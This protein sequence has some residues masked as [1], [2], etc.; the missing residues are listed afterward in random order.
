MNMDSHSPRKIAAVI[1]ATALSVGLTTTV[2]VQQ[3][4]DPNRALGSLKGLHPPLPNLDGIVRDRNAAIVLDKALFWDQQAGSDGVACASCHFH[5]GADSRIRNQLSPGLLAGDTRFGA[6]EPPEKVG[7][8]GSGA[9]ADSN[10]TLVALDFPFHQLANP[11]DR[12]SSIVISTNDV[13]SSQGTLAGDFI[14]IGRSSTGQRTPFNNF[15]PVEDCGP[16]DPTIFH[17]GPYAAR[18]VEPR[19]APSVVNA[20]SNFRNFWDGRA[21]NIF[22]GVDPFGRRNLTASI[23]VVQ[24]DGSV[25]PV[26]VRLENARLASQ[27]VGPPLSSF[28]M[29]CAGKTFADLGR[30]L[31]PTRPLALQRVDPNDSVLGADVDRA[32]GTGLKLPYASYVAAAF[33]PKYWASRQTLN[34]YS[35]MESNFSFFWGISVMLYESTL[36]SDDSPFDRFMGCPT[37]QCNP[38]VSPNLTALTDAQKRGFEVFKGK[39]RCI[40]CH[41]GPEFSKAATHLQGE[42]QEMGLVERMRMGDGGVALYDNGFYNIGVRPAGEDLGVG[43]K[44]PFGNPLSFTRQYVARLKGQNVRDPF[45]VDPCTFEVPFNVD[46]FPGQPCSVE[47]TDPRQIDGLR[48]AVDGAFKVPILR[49]VGLTP[50]YF[51]NGGTATLRQVVDFYNRGGDRRGQDGD[52]TTGTGPLGKGGET[53]VIPTSSPRGS[54]L[55]PDITVLGLTAQ[56]IQDLLVFLLAL[57]DLRVACE[58]SPFDHPE[59]VV[60]NGHLVADSNGDGRADDILLTK[61]AVGVGGLP[62]LGRACIPN[63]GNLFDMQ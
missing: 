63:T 2:W 13:A 45:Q 59:L 6:T 61:P 42:A 49:N 32:S 55:D 18:K 28:E 35:Q 62:A 20:G 8:T 17:A 53:G 7:L 57:T 44:D 48:L 34:G 46:L 40:N 14:S 21:N 31:L 4:Q 51:H 54:N 50:P 38:A 26:V 11:L 1:F 10:Y 12:N 60:P 30:K 56:E 29:S 47:P 41:D 24:A 3:V 22:N 58:K 19:Q 15:V 27:A 16:A 52:D 5:G 25:A 39:G 43:A 9:V 36:V 37:P 23:L 33:D